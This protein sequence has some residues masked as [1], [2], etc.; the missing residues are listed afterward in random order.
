MYFQSDGVAN[1]YSS[2]S[3]SGLYGDLTYQVRMK[4]DGGASLPNYIVI[5]GAASPLGADGQ[6]NK[7]YRFAYNNGGKY[8]I[9]EVTGNVP[10]ARKNWT[11]SAA[12]VPNNWNS[13]KLIAVGS[14]MK[15]YI[16]GTLV[17]TFTD[18]SYTTGAV[19]FGFSRDA[20]VG[21]MY[22]DWATL[23]TTATADEA[24]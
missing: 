3:H 13:L 1:Q 11:S 12:I 8:S 24:P 15:F 17:Y 19:G 23:S 22:V 18:T 20:S 9:W 21:T 16:N 2:A 5:R 7:E 4:R 10:T 6:W 14:T